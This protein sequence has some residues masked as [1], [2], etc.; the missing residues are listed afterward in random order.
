MSSQVERIPRDLP[1]DVRDRCKHKA[2]AVLNLAPD[3]LLECV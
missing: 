1:R 2:L 3:A